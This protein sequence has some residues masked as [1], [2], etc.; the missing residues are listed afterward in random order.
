MHLP[1]SNLIALAAWAVIG[2]AACATIKLRGRR[3]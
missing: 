3:R 1:L 2:L